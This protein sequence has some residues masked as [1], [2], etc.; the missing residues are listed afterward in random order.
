MW[1]VIVSRKMMKAPEREMQTPVGESNSDPAVLCR[2]SR[3]TEAAHGSK[4]LIR[5]ASG[6]QAIQATGIKTFT[7]SFA[8]Y[9]LQSL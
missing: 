9:R 8:M 7:F 3:L 6:V 4:T 2:G 5:G 1:L